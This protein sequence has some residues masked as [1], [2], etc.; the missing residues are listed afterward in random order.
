MEAPCQLEINGQN[1][2][3]PPQPRTFQD[4]D[5]LIKYVRDFGA[6][7]GYVV[8]IKKSKKDRR[9]LLG[10]DRGGVYRNR[11]KIEEG[12]RK[13]KVSSRLINCPFEAVGKK[14]D[15]VWV[16]TIKNG[17]HNHEP[18]KDMSEH[19]YSRRFTEE[20]VWQIKLMTEAGIKPRQVLKA[21]KQTNPD[22]QSTPR[23]L[24]NVKAKIR[25][26]NI[27]DKSFK[28]WRPNVSAP[29]DTSIETSTCVCPLKVTN[30]IGGKFVESQA[31]EI[32]DVINPATQEIISQVPTTTYEEFKA[33]VTAAKHAFPAWKNTT[34]S[35]RRRIMFKLE[36]LIRRDIDK[37]AMSI[38][39]EQGKTLH[40]AKG[41]LLYGLEIVE[42]TCGMATLQIGEYL[43]NA[44]N[45]VD[46]YCFREPLGVCAGICPSS[47]PSMIPLWMFPI[48]VT[49]GNTFILKSSEHNTGAAMMIAAL[50]AEAGL[51]AGVL[52]IIHGNHEIVNNICDDDDIK[53]IS[54][55]SSK[56]A[57][58]HIYPRAAAKGKCIQSNMGVKNHVIIMPDAS[59]DATLDALVASGFGASKVHNCMSP[60]IAVFVGGSAPWEHELVERAK[61]LKVNAGT[62]A[63]VDIGPVISKEAKNRICRLIQSGIESGARLVLDGRHVV[64]PWYENGNFVGPTIMCNVTAN[65]DCYKEDMLG[66]VLLCMQAE[67]LEEAI[68]IV[69]RSKHGNGASI[70]TSSAVYARKFQNEVENGLVGINVPVPLSLPFSMFNGSEAAFASDLNFCGKAGVQFFTRIKSVVQQWKELPGRRVSFPCPPPSETEISSQEIAMTQPPT[71]ESDVNGCEM[72]PAMP[73]PSELPS[74]DVSLS[75]LPTSEDELANTEGFLSISSTA[76]RELSSREATVLMPPETAMDARD[77]G[78][79]SMPP[80]QTSRLG[81]TTLAFRQSENM[82]SGEGTYMALTSQR[83]SKFSP[84]IQAMDINVAATPMS[85]RSYIPIRCSDDGVSPMPLRND[86]ICMMSFGHDLHRTDSDRIYMPLFSQ[87][88]ENVVPTSQRPDMIYLSTSHGNDDVG[89]ISLRTGASVHP[90]PGSL[91]MSASY[92]TDTVPPQTTNTV[93]ST[94]EMYLQSAVQSND[95][96]ASTS[97]SIFVPATSQGMYIQTPIVSMDEYRGQVASQTRQTSKQE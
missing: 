65:M 41:D 71:Y 25:Q 52:N 90:A 47:Y 12:K 97:E 36:D 28:S 57:L 35:T 58:M 92:K 3:L 33:A 14:D 18:L 49:C 21:L 68:A 61:I 44:T 84:P 34:A 4:R 39:T 31:C 5:N 1:L 45:G 79:T 15:D 19:P 32:I 42:Q 70:F 17:E 48:A 2:M 8:T 76:E 56:T 16:L 73:P 94:S 51:P 83:I 23:H 55:V 74:H 53:A 20:E 78:P 11:R 91:C 30:Y 37:I 66:P 6:S 29:V 86:S 87:Q 24:Y 43:P 54:S 77:R 62:E 75:F 64:V 93:H 26:G 85:E 7:Q 40:G 9:V 63:G 50:A 89:L 27:S 72:S 38:A 46:A 82:S 60:S 95:S 81:E 69:N 96:T 13:R 67:S 88:N 22:L 10:C 80:P 59:A